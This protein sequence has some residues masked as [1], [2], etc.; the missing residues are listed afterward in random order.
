[1]V[2]RGRTHS[3]A[4]CAVA[5]HLVGRIWAVIKQNRPYGWHDLDGNPIDRGQARQLALSLRVDSQTR[6]RLRSRTKRGS[7]AP[8]ARQPQAPRNAPQPSDN[9]L[10]EAA[11]EVARTS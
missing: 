10:I 8:R 11:M 5:S 9:D 7:E 4:L 6:A 3:Q 2:E 1:M